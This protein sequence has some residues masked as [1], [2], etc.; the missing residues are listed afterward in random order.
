MHVHSITWK[1]HVD[2]CKREKSISLAFQIAPLYHGKC[3]Y[4]EW[5]RTKSKLHNFLVH[6]P[7]NQSE[8]HQ[9]YR[10]Y[11]RMTLHYQDLTERLR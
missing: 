7:N 1:N 2:Y 10:K 3:S 5:H 8:M 4:L 11:K 9:M 6:G